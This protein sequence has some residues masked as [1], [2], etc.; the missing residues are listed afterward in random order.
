MDASTY[1]HLIRKITAV[2]VINKLG[3]EYVRIKKN[4]LKQNGVMNSCKK[5]HISC[6]YPIY[7]NT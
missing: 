7:Q 5:P 4:D 2:D 1:K 3:F 6:A